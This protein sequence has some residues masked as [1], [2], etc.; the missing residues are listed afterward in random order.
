M[1][2]TMNTAFDSPIGITVAGTYQSSYEAILSPEALDFLTALHEHFDHRRKLLLDDRH[3]RQLLFNQGQFPDLPSGLYSSTSSSEWQVSPISTCL[4]ERKVEL[5]GA[6]LK[7]SI[8]RAFES[9]AHVFIAD[10]EDMMTPSWSNIVEGQLHLHEAVFLSPRDNSRAEDAPVTESTPVIFV[11]PRG[12]HSIEMHLE[13]HGSPACGAFIDF[14]LYL[15]LNAHELMRQGHGP[16]FVLSKL[17]SQQE[18]K[19]WNDVFHF[20]QSYLGIPSGTIK[21]SISI[22]TVPALFE[23]EQILYQ[24]KEHT[25]DL[26]CHLWGLV[27]AHLIAFQ[28]HKRLTLPN[29]DQLTTEQSLIKVYADLVTHI[30]HKRGT[31]AMSQ[32]SACESAASSDDLMIEKLIWEK[33]R[34]VMA[35][36]DGT[37][38]TNPNL[39]DVVSTVFNKNMKGKNQIHEKRHDVQIKAS[40]L[41]S[42]PTGTVTEEGIRKNVNDTI[43]YFESWLADRTSTT[44]P[45]PVESNAKAEVL[46]SQLWQWLN[47]PTYLPDGR[48]VS[49]KLYRR[50]RQ[51]ELLKIRDKIGRQKFSKGRFEDAVKLLDELVLADCFSEH[52]SISGYQMLN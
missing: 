15:F 36:F 7:D 35:G 17:E 9:K 2:P 42:A 23:A 10:F 46:R 33:E 40:D 31:H 12:L 22:E 4:E 32:L 37:T 1:I 13:I 5:I 6:P 25:A 8:E 43:V 34:E 19:L 38:I 44:L 51:E 27:H 20:A 39:I 48:L 41:I 49:E 16:F 18:A 45:S 3:Q 47:H 26:R 30:S 50:C 24:L 14:G 52:F 29:A 21:A 28:G 11:K